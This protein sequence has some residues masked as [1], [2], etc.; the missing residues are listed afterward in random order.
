KVDDAKR[1][2]MVNMDADVVVQT[3]TMVVASSKVSTTMITH[4][5]VSTIR[6]QEGAGQGHPKLDCQ[7][8][9]LDTVQNKYLRAIIRDGRRQALNERRVDGVVRK[10]SPR[11]QPSMPTFISAFTI[12]S[13]VAIYGK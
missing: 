6:E 1:R 4:V 12:L 11:Q 13:D 7:Y 3:S 2:G 5:D 9:A 8:V 10:L